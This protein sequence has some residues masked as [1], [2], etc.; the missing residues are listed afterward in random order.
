[1]TG[2]VLRRTGVWLTYPPDSPIPTVVP[3]ASEL[4]ALRLAALAGYRAVFVEYGT[5]LPD[6]VNAPPETESEPT[7]AGPPPGPF[8][9]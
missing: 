2:K 5:D 9:A 1:M 6:A 4:K 7:D 3:Y 8:A